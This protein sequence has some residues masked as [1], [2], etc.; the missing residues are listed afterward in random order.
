[1]RSDHLQNQ[2]AEIFHGTT[3][4]LFMPTK[5]IVDAWQGWTADDY[6]VGVKGVSTGFGDEAGVKGL[7]TGFGERSSSPDD[8][9]QG[10]NRTDTASFEIQRNVASKSEPQ[11][12][13]KENINIAKKEKEG[14]EEDNRARVDSIVIAIATARKR[15]VV[16]SRPTQGLQRLEMDQNC[17]A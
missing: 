16:S 15:S 6:E 7:S 9:V 4:P 11:E 13:E 12:V 5:T 3:H 2:I 10:D 14:E 17:G 1:M 8:D